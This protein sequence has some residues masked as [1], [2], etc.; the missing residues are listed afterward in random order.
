MSHGNITHYFQKIKVLFC[1]CKQGIT[2]RCG[3]AVDC[4]NGP[5]LS[6]RT[7]GFAREK[8]LHGGRCLLKSG[9]P[10]QRLACCQSSVLVA[11]V[12]SNP[13]RSTTTKNKKAWVSTQAAPQTPPCDYTVASWCV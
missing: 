1:R 3:T 4:R 10:G 11:G 12:D 2:M 9:L 5:D 8:I 6:S 7:H 13:A